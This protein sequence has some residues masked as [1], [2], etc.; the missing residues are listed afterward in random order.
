V[1][2][3]TL[4]FYRVAATFFF[5]SEVK[6]FRN[7][8]RKPDVYIGPGFSNIGIYTARGYIPVFRVYS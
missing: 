6:S 3:I 4:L 8:R 1:F 7:L 5:F 2:I